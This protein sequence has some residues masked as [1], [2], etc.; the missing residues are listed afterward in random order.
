MEHLARQ[1]AQQCVKK[2]SFIVQELKMIWDVKE[3]MNVYH[4]MMY[5][6]TL[7]RDA[8]RIAQLTAYQMSN[9]V[10]VQLILTVVLSLICV[11]KALKM[12]LGM[13][14]VIHS[15]QLNAAKK[16]CYVQDQSLTADVAP[17]LTALHLQRLL[18]VTEPL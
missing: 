15:V 7:G 14:L 4:Q 3:Q 16:S 12:M 9:I 18:I 6:I 8:P 5:L 17:N 2:I 13:L 11:P 1:C 10:Q